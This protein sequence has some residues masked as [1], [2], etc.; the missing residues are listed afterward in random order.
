MKDTRDN[1]RDDMVEED[2]LRRLV[3]DGE[4][5]IEIPSEQELKIIIT[6]DW[7]EDWLKR[8]SKRLIFF[9]YVGGCGGEY[10]VNT[11][12]ESFYSTA[13]ESKKWGGG[14]ATN[15]RHFSID[16]LFDNFFTSG[17]EDLDIENFNDL[18]RELLKYFSSTSYWA[19]NDVGTIHYCL[20]NIYHFD[21]IKEHAIVRLHVV[22][23]CM[24]LFED[25]VKISLIPGSQQWGE[26]TYI[27][28]LLK[29]TMVPL[30][31]REDKISYINEEFGEIRDDGSEVDLG[32]LFNE[33]YLSS[34]ITDKSFF[35]ELYNAENN[36]ITKNNWA[37]DLVIKILD[38]HNKLDDGVMLFPHTI[39]LLLLEQYYNKYEIR[40]TTHEMNMKNNVNNFYKEHK[41]DNEWHSE[42]NKQFQ[43]HGFGENTYTMDDVINGKI[44]E[45]FSKNVN[46]DITKSMFTN[47]M[48]DWCNNNIEFY[49]R[50]GFTYE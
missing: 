4:K 24:A 16:H 46:L 18:A 11:M 28:Q 31:T 44:L 10:I 21:M 36:A 41:Y 19:K 17:Y 5:N 23:K 20:S 37:N 45:S 39:I 14:N 35:A 43:I 29:T 48:K 2:S 25:S 33:D 50:I 8:V 13:L 42:F 26:Y 22:D 6:V 27:A 1:V 30:Y 40:C 7:L 3:K 47:S 34:V 49:E 38:N 32:F 15:N 12:Q 9:S